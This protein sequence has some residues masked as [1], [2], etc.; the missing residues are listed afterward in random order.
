MATLADK[1]IKQDVATLRQAYHLRRREYDALRSAGEWAGTV[2]HA[3]VLVELALKIAICKNMDVTRLP[4]AFQVHELEFLLYCSGLE[5]TFKSNPVL[6]DNFNLIADKWSMELRYQGAAVAQH[7]SDDFH[8]ALF[9][10]SS[11]VLTFLT[12]IL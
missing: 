12:S 8:R 5:K 3:G 2:L 7:D 1:L 6:Y 4:K 10:T 11:G 9:D